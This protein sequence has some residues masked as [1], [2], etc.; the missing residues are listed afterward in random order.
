MMAC[1]RWC[2]CSIG[3]VTTVY[4][5]SVSE[6]GKKRASIEQGTASLFPQQAGSVR[7]TGREAWVTGGNACLDDAMMH[8]YAHDYADNACD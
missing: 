5:E 2:I 7:Q 6:I 8:T 4:H 3:V 1:S